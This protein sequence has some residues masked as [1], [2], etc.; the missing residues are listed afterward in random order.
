MAD[1]HVTGCQ[2]CGKPT[3]LFVSSGK[4]AK[5]CSEHTGQH[6]PSGRLVGACCVCGKPTKERNRRGPAPKYCKDHDHQ[7]RNLAH[8]LACGIGPIGAGRKYCS[9]LC[10]EKARSE[11]KKVRC[12]CPSCGSVRFTQLNRGDNSSRLCKKCNAKRATLALSVK[13]ADRRAEKWTP[14]V[15]RIWIVVCPLTGEAT[16]TSRVGTAICTCSECRE[17]RK[18]VRLCKCGSRLGYH[19]S[20]CDGCKRKAKRSAR[21]QF[22]KSAAYRRLRKAH[23]A[24]RK[25]RKRGAS[26]MENVMP[27]EIFERDHWRCVSCR[28]TTPREL[29]GTNHGNEPT[30]DHVVP[31]ARGG[32]HTSGNLQLLCRDCNTLKGT[33]TMDEFVQWM[34]RAA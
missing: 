7:S 23:R 29:I 26:E 5:F 19:R 31:L 12:E 8:C 3:K 27:V 16:R 4:S 25:A 24:K 11:R 28:C 18:P 1:G 34:R 22:K 13:A 20:K 10:A 33:M 14:R 2:I 30:L 9:D 17:A 15:S 6:V 21:R 32:T